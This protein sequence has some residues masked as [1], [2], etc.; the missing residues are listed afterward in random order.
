[1][2]LD[3]FQTVNLGWHLLLELILSFF[4]WLFLHSHLALLMTV[5]PFKDNERILSS[6]SDKGMVYTS[7]GQI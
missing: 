7:Y 5:L 2:L 4:A 3:S 6:F 1:M